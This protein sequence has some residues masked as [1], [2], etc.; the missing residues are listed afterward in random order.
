M[1]NDLINIDINAFLLKKSNDILGLALL[2]IC[3]RQRAKAD[4]PLA[5]EAIPLLWGKVFEVSIVK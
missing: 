2:S 3:I 4:I 1:D 5:E